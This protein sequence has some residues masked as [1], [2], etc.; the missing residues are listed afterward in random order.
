MSAGPVRQAVRGAVA[1]RRVQT[2]VVGLV[3]L[4][5]TAASVLAA[6]LVVD[7][8]SPFDHAF[9]AQHGAHLTATIDTARVTPAL[10]AA[11]THLAGVTAAAGPFPEAVILPEQAGV[12]ASVG[13]LPPLTLAGRRS[14]A[15]RWTTS[16][17]ARATGR[18]GPASSCWPATRPA[19]SRSRCRWARGSS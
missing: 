16:R 8:S 2:L 7:S 3:L 4:V 6:A 5:S 11:T 15:A 10:L 9:A 1:R 18:S 19:P 12:P 17:S 13:K 14:R